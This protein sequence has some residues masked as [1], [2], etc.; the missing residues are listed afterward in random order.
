VGVRGVVSLAE[1]DS[2]VWLSESDCTARG[3]T[4]MPLANVKMIHLWIGPGYTDAPIFAHDNP[5]LY[6]GFNPQIEVQA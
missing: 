3:G 5:E 4:V 6:D 1:E 2:P